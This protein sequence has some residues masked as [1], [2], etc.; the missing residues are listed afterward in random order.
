M[1]GGIRGGNSLIDVVHACRGSVDV[2]V[3][4]VVAEAAHPVELAYLCPAGW[5]QL[6][7]CHFEQH[8]MRTFT[9]GSEPLVDEHSSECEAQSISARPRSQR[10]ITTEAP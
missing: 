9:T 7:D 3:L 10:L 5:F 6:S 2:R 4:G 1:T 8:R